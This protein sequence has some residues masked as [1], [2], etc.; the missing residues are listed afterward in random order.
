[1]LAFALRAT[2]QTKGL[3]SSTPAQLLFPW[4]TAGFCGLFGTPPPPTPTPRGRRAGAGFPP[5]QAGDLQASGGEAPGR[6]AG[7]PRAP[8]RAGPAAVAPG[9]QPR[10]RHLGLGLGQ[11]RE[12]KSRAGR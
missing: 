3:R 2:S 5:R 6:A 8:L 1:M 10:R 9:G 7:A 12:G 11:A 4:A